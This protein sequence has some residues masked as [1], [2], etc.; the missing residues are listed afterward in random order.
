MATDIDAL[1]DCLRYDPETGQLWWIKR[2]PYRLLE[3]KLAASVDRKGYLVVGFRNK[4]L[5][6]HR[7]IWMIMM[8]TPVPKGMTIDHVNG[9]RS[10]NRWTNLRLANFV[11]QS[12]NRA[13]RPDSRTGLKGVHFHKPSGKW[14]AKIQMPLGSRKSLGL[15]HSAEEAQAAYAAASRLHY[16]DFARP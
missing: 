8:G 13:L 2:P 6:A 16:G 10:D 11:Q 12:H 7:V 14:Q 4:I 9:D 1:R 5:K 3:P 15:F